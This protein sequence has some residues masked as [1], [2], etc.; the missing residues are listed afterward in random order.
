MLNDISGYSVPLNLREME[1]NKAPLANKE[2]NT[3]EKILDSFG[4]ILNKQIS[5]TNVIQIDAEKAQEIFATGGNIS[6]HEVMIKAEKAEM[7][8]QLT[9]QLRNKLLAA[10][11]E[12]Q[13]MHV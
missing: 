1:A 4:E 13:S 9:L 7:S 8:M 6:L 3:S 10:Y 12:I 2:I 11:K 5:E